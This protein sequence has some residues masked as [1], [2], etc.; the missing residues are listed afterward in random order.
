MGR[1]FGYKLVLKKKP[2]L[3]SGLKQERGLTKDAHSYSRVSLR[4]YNVGS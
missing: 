1:I 3:F 2:L 4:D